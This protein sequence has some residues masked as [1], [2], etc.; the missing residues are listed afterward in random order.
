MEA[1]CSS[2]A[3]E[4]G[5]QRIFGIENREVPV[6]HQEMACAKEV[7]PKKYHCD[8]VELTSGSENFQEA[9]LGCKGNALH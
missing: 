6:V 1:R 5:A 2:C 7:L 9:H 4:R 3:P 8:Q